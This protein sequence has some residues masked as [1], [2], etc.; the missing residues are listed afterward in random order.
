MASQILRG[1]GAQL[2]RRNPDTLLFIAV[3]QLRVI[4]APSATQNYADATNHDS[5]GSF[6]ENIDTFKAG[7]EVALVLVYHP[8]IEMHKQIYLD[9]IAQTKL[10]WR[11]LLSNTIDGWEFEG[12]VSKF[13]MPLNFDAPVF[14]NWSIKVTGLPTA[15]EI[16]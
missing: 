14:L 4:P 7:D 12:R 9:F 1:K 2:Y 13:D 11:T 3:P 6:E 5:P 16:S 15:V 8:D 10:L